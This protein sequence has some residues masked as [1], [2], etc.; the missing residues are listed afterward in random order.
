MLCNPFFFNG[1]RLDDVEVVS[2][3]LEHSFLPGAVCPSPYLPSPAKTLTVWAEVGRTSSTLQ[4][5]WYRVLFV[6]PPALTGRVQ[7]TGWGNKGLT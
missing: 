4:G 7:G 3:V 6:T 2:S 5:G 1:V